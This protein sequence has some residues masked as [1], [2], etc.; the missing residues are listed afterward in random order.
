MGFQCSN[1]HQ[2]L[3]Y[4]KEKV[5]NEILLI[6][7]LLLWVCLLAPPS[8]ISLVQNPARYNSTFKYIF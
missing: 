1:F 5:T 3:P 7:L 2:S 4:K 8:E 6:S